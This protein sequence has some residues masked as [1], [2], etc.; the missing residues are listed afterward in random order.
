MRLVIWVRLSTARLFV[1]SFPTATIWEER[2]FGLVK[3]F[4]AYGGFTSHAHC[5]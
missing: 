4:V 2:L 1:S 3:S 5:G